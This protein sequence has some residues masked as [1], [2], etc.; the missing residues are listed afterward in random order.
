MSRL[1]GVKIQPRIPM[2]GALGQP[3]PLFHPGDR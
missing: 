3:R 2:V 1:T